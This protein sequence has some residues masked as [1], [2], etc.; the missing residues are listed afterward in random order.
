MIQIFGCEQRARRRG[1]VLRIVTGPAADTDMLA[2]ER[3]SG[4][5]V[6]KAF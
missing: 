5:R 4:L 2:V 6:I 1:N 3:V